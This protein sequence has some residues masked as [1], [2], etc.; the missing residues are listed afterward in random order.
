MLMFL[1]RL[2]SSDFYGMFV[3]IIFATGLVLYV[4]GHFYNKVQSF[5]TS[6]VLLGL[7]DQITPY[8]FFMR[9]IGVILML[10]GI[11]YEG[12]YNSDVYWKTKLDNLAAKVQVAEQR[13]NDANGQIKTKII[14][15]TKVITKTVQVEKEKL[16]ESSQKIDSG[17]VVSPEAI[18]I[19]NSAA[20]GVV[21]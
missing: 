12:S 6:G 17:C 1:L 14:Y 18:D 10:L 8:A 3:H 2:V 11:Y 21:K 20:K 19:I 9:T 13:A 7:I 16:K 15:K 5:S 4:L